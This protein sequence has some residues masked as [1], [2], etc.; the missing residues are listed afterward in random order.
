VGAVARFGEGRGA[1]FVGGGCEARGG[2]PNA[3]ASHRKRTA[4]AAAGVR[5]PP[6]GAAA[7]GSPQRLDDGGGGVSLKFLPLARPPPRRARHRG[8]TRRV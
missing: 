6:T 4:S 5:G 7:E 2:L 8:A 1:R 3:P